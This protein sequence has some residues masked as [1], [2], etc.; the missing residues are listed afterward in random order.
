M[1]D[2]H[3]FVKF[4]RTVTN[5]N[6]KIINWLNALEDGPNEMN[7]AWH[8][9]RDNYTLVEFANAEDAMAFKL[10]FDLDWMIVGERPHAIQS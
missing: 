6:M 10:A 2:N 3:I 4:R 1:N 5:D 7:K 8:Y 9:W